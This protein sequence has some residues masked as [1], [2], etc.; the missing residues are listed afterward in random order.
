MIT[1][2]K[3]IALISQTLQTDGPEIGFDGS[4]APGPGTVIFGEGSPLD[5]MGL[6][7]FIA[8]LE[9][10]LSRETGQAF[11]LADER[12]MSRSRSPF[13][14]VDALAEF[15]CGLSREH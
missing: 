10:A 2:E 11:I 8:D 7:I 4:A 12:A 9:A 5:S 1:K 6:V 13:R 14:T 15:I 3:A